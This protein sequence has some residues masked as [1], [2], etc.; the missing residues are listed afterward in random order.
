MKERVYLHKKLQGNSSQSNIINSIKVIDE[1]MHLY[2]Q[3]GD[4]DYD[5]EPISQSSHMIQCAMLAMAEGDPDL[6]IGSFLH[7]IGHLLK[8]NHNTETMGSFGIVNHEGIGAEY[9]KERGF[10]E[11]VCAIVANHVAAKRYL[12]ATDKTYASRLSPASRETLQWQGGPMTHEEA[13]AFEQ[14][15]YFSD[16]IKVRFWDEQAKDSN[17]PILPLNFFQK[18]IFNYLNGNI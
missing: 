4:E 11:R 6:T 7:D 9:L 5:G 2:L 18:F 16:I 13:T 10:S 14:H 15:P 17:I 3:Y 8:H 12:M 1:I